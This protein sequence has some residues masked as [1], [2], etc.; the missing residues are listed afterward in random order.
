MKGP[1]CDPGDTGVIFEAFRRGTGAGRG[2]VGLG[3]A[4]VRGFAEANG[5][6]VWLESP[7]EGGACFVL[8]LPLAPEPRE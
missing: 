3:L 5:G 1:V 4:I 8:A 7:A 2:G 6:R